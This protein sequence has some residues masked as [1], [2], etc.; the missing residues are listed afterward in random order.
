MLDNPHP[1]SLVHRAP[2]TARRSGWYAAVD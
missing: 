2:C 1:A